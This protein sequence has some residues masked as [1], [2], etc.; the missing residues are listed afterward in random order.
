MEQLLISQP[1]PALS[2]CLFQKKDTLSWL[3]AE[4]LD[5]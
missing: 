4:D 5:L 3:L 2:T 1:K